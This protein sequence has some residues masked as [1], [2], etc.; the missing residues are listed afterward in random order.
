MGCGGFG[1]GGSVRLTDSCALGEP[2]YFEQPID[3]LVILSRTGKK[4]EVC[5]T[6]DG[7]IFL[8]EVLAK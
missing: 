7:E 3:R 1:E 2:V 8:R 5:E 6:V 4:W